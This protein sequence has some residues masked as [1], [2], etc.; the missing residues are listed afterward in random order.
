M[1]SRPQYLWVVV[2]G[3]DF[4]VR[5][6]RDFWYFFENLLKY[7]EIS[8]N[9]LKCPLPSYGHFYTYTVIWALRPRLF[10]AQLRFHK[11]YEDTGRVFSWQKD[12]ASVL[13]HLVESQVRLEEPRSECPEYSIRIEM[14]GW[15]QRK[16]LEKSGQFY[17]IPA[18]EFRGQ[19]LGLEWFCPR[20]SGSP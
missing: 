4:R 11:M 19:T 1:I 2:T 9:F 8:W 6:G 20:K 17:Q 5:A 12:P 14:S 7:L 16:F 18:M 10:Q 15:R 13:I 3:L